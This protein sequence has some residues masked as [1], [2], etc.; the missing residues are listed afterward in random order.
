MKKSEELHRKLRDVRTDVEEGLI[1]LINKV[2]EAFLSSNPEVE[3]AEDLSWIELPNSIV[4]SDNDDGNLIEAIERVYL[5]GQKVETFIMGD[6]TER[7]IDELT[8]MQLIGIIEQLEKLSETPKK[9][10]IV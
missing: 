5:D 6:G 2:K 4:F 1:T 10:E 7:D 8:E 9:I 3:S